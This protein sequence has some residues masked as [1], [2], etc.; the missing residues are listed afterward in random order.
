MSIYEKK[1]LIVNKDRVF[2]DIYYD[3]L[4]VPN[5]KYNYKTYIQGIKIMKPQILE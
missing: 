1:S 3:H 5:C 4:I 2:Y